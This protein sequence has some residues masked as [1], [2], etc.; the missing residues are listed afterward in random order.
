MASPFFK[1][2]NSVV[3][4]TGATP[5]PASGYD[6][7][8]NPMQMFKDLEAELDRHIARAQGAPP[9]ELTATQIMQQMTAA[10][11][12]ARADAM[13]RG[14]SGAMQAM[15]AQ[16]AAHA[17][18]TAAMQRFLQERGA[19]PGSM[20]D[21]DDMLVGRI[22]PAPLPPAR[23]APAQLPPGYSPYWDYHPNDPPWVRGSDVLAACNTLL[24]GQA[25]Q[26]YDE[27][28]GA[29]MAALSEVRMVGHPV[30]FVLTDDLAR[31]QK[32][33]MVRGCF[34]VPFRVPSP[35]LLSLL[36]SLH[37]S[38]GWPLGAAHVMLA[39]PKAVKEKL[40]ALLYHDVGNKPDV[41]A[42]EEVNSVYDAAKADPHT[43]KALDQLM[44]HGFPKTGERMYRPLANVAVSVRVDSLL[45]GQAAAP[46][47]RTA[48]RELVAQIVGDV[49][50]GLAY[51]RT[52]ME[53]HRDRMMMLAKQCVGVQP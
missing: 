33:L 32:V 38:E 3:T 52:P 9:P 31:A 39:G 25:P 49:E 8:R 35:Q 20:Q 18:V 15:A 26:Q 6:T 44:K 24:K 23:V 27:A 14:M 50:S 4:P 53:Q 42:V 22:P 12:Q 21:W 43:Y 45:A 36:Q 7:A 47:M 37:I 10:A 34:G 51:E 11:A 40:S 13:N 48:A 16:N 5:G 30:K 46:A 17:P 1:K 29:F 19:L 41:I 28:M 2:G